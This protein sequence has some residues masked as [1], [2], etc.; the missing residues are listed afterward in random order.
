MEESEAFPILRRSLREDYTPIVGKYIAV[1]LAH[2]DLK[3]DEN[4][5]A[6][7]Q[8]GKTE[9]GNETQTLSHTAPRNEA[10]QTP[11]DDQIEKKV[12]SSEVKRHKT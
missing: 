6:P 8:N 7:V 10:P 12:R 11:Q 4:S 5:P 2:I 1:L 9:L 3:E